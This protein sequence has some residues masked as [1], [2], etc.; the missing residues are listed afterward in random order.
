MTH[1]QGKKKPV[2]TVFE[3]GWTVDLLDKDYYFLLIFIGV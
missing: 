3:E 1:T 2:E